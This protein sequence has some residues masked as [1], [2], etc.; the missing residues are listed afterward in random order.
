MAGTAFYL[1]TSIG[2][3]FRLIA[4]SYTRM[5]LYLNLASLCWSKG[6]ALPYEHLWRSAS[7]LQLHPS[8]A[9]CFPAIVYHMSRLL[10]DFCC[11]GFTWTDE[12]PHPAASYGPPPKAGPSLSGF[13]GALTY[14]LS[15]AWRAFLSL[16]A[17]TYFAPAVWRIAFSFFCLAHYLAES[18]IDAKFDCYEKIACPRRILKDSGSSAD[19]SNS[20]FWDFETDG[21]L[22]CG[23]TME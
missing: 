5:Y 22:D 12:L 2:P 19:D 3:R 15:S 18:L 4:S 10:I 23:A 6:F 17:S 16:F 7:S 11:L 20:R 21:Q 8:S 1:I 13:G 9:R 14:F